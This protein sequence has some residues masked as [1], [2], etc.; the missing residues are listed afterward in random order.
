MHHGAAVPQS[1]PAPRM[2]SVFLV[3][4]ANPAWSDLRASLTSMLDVAIVG[5]VGSTGEALSQAPC[6]APD[7]LIVAAPVLY[8]LALSVVVGLLDRC[9]SSRFIVVAEHLD[10]AEFHT[11]KRLGVTD[12][13]VWSDL[14]GRFHRCFEQTTL[15]GERVVSLRDDAEEFFDALRWRQRP[16]ADSMVLSLVERAVLTGKAAGLRYDEIAAREHVRPATVKRTTSRLQDRLEVP[17]QYI[18][19]MHARDLSLMPEAPPAQMNHVAG[20]TGH[21]ALKGSQ[22]DRRGSAR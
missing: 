16:A 1:N 6:L 14:A 15:D 11:I 3:R 22:V 13:L 20:R 7:L 12:Y 19:A 4:S 2:R 21:V 18:L 10:R 5:D 17:W 9:A 8:V